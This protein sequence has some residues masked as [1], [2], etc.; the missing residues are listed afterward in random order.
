MLYLARIFRMGRSFSHHCSLG[1]RCLGGREREWCDGPGWKQCYIAWGRVPS[2]YLS[3]PGLGHGLG[4]EGEGGHLLEIR[5]LLE[6]SDGLK[7]EAALAHTQQTSRVGRVGEDPTCEGRWGVS[8]AFWTLE[9][10]RAPPK[11]CTGVL[12]I[13][14]LEHTCALG[15]SRAF[16]F[17]HPTLWLWGRVGAFGNKAE[18]TPRCGTHHAGSSP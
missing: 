17:G 13:E 14:I 7:D 5:L 10:G 1:M 18:K 2:L 16:S 9:E 11:I 3:F 8:S 15:K 12:C 4:V 6:V